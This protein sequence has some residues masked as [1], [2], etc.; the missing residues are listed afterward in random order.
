MTPEQLNLLTDVVLRLVHACGEP[1]ERLETRAYIE[2]ARGAWPGEGVAAWSKWIA[3]ATRSLGLRSR[4]AVL[5]PQQAVDIALAGGHAAAL[6]PSGRPVLLLAARAGVIVEDDRSMG[7]VEGES[8]VLSAS[9]AVRRVEGVIGPEP[10]T[11]LLLEA[12]RL[13]AE[14]AAISSARRPFYRLLQVWAPEWSDIW[15][16]IVFAFFY[17]LLSL[18]TPIA[19]ESL[20]NTVAFGQLL[21]PILVLSTMLIAV[22]SFGAMVRAFQTLVVEIIQRRMFVRVT[23]DLAHRLPRVEHSALDSHYG[24]ELANR[25]F[26]IV[27][28]QKVTAA[29]LLDGVGVLMAT[30]FGMVILAFYHPYL[31]G[32]DVVLLILVVG[33]LL[34][35]GRGAISTGIQ[36]SKYKYRIAAWLQDM[37]RCHEAFKLAGAD[38]FAVDRANYL[39]SHY[40][41]A[42]RKHFAKLFGQVTYSLGLQAIAGTVLLGGGGWLVTQAQLSLGQL[43][44]AELIVA[45]ILNALVKFAKHFDGFYDAIA[46]VDKLGVLFDLPLERQDGLLGLSPEP[47]AVRL[48]E[49][50]H[51]HAQGVLQSGL[52]CEIGPLECVAL[53]GPPGSGK[54]TLLDMLFGL[55]TPG[56]GHID[57]GGVDPREVRPDVLRGWVALAREHEVL[58]ITVAENIHLRR[59]G[60]TL[61]EV[62][63]ALQ[64]VGLLETIL[65]LPEGLDQMLCSSGAPLSSTQ[66][67]QL[68]L[69]RAMVGRPKLLLIDGLL[70]RLSDAQAAAVLEP[71]MRPGRPWSLIVATGQRDVAEALPRIISLHPEM[72]AVE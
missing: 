49:L 38:A 33:G 43:V 5:T 13:H 67:S 18:A 12:P 51:P 26:D 59:P 4:Q 72:A 24:P 37:V 40:L 1:A 25:F 63:Q 21:Q 2:Q 50:T 47:A 6:N 58:N 23:A 31:L 11:W 46:S 34:L 68:M 70:D 45:N 32:F 52:T 39:T 35:I 48:R 71:L 56:S 42:R 54:S 36:E 29:L 19:V 55:R 17:G 62:R 44:A 10:L 53:L 8:G 64:D 69:A 66:Q 9:Q 30:L 60:V 3:E 57:L 61:P 28:L 7:G 22:L 14:S 15:V 16:V 20:V 27:T 41:D 65:A